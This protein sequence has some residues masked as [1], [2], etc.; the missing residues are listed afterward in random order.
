MGWRPLPNQSAPE[1]RPLTDSLD[2]VAAS[3]GASNASSL[4]AIF[5]SWPSL[6]GESL[7]LHASPKSLHKGVLVIA[8]EEPAWATQISWLEADMISRIRDMAGPESVER[9][10]VVVRR[11][12]VRGDTVPGV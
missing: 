6:V 7:A 8:V 9:I 12:D 11:R 3:L 4:T 10:E 5:T 2:R 1:P